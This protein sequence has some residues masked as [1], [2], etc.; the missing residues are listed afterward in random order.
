LLWT[1][2]PGLAPL[3]FEELKSTFGGLR[4]TLQDRGY[5]VGKN[6]F[7]DVRDSKAMFPGCRP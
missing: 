5:A 7:V 4:D 1:G 3:S 2:E 6:H